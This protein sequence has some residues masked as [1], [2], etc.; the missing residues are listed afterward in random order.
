VNA[1][2]LHEND[3][4]KLWGGEREK[5]G[6][7]VNNQEKDLKKER[8][9]EKPAK[10]LLAFNPTEEA[11]QILLQERK[12]QSGKDCWGG[13]PEGGGGGGNVRKFGF[14]EGERKKKKPR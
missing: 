9:W 5:K 12:T 2:G 14:C 6:T 8:C 4:G 11:Q 13:R 1:T 10:N 3:V 7:S